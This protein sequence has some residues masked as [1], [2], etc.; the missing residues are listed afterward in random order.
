M[1]FIIFACL[2]RIRYVGLRNSHPDCAL[3]GYGDSPGLHPRLGLF[4]Y[5]R[6]SAPDEWGAGMIFALFPILLLIGLIVGYGVRDIVRPRRAAAA[7]ERYFE[8][9]EHL[10]E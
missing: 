9:H 4:Y 3:S 5:E 1:S 10:R 2:K 8:R 6:K 7:R